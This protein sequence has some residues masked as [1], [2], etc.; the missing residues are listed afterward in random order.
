MQTQNR[1]FTIDNAIEDCGVKGLSYKTALEM[2][3]A[4]IKP[5]LVKAK[6]PTELLEAQV[7]AT[8]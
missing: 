6:A 7:D 1:V 4:Q 3:E 8:D 5:C 2:N